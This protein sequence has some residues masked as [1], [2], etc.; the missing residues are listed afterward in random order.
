M[1]AD[2]NRTLALTEA[3]TGGVSGLDEDLL[4]I[5]CG[6]GMEKEKNAWITRTVN[7][8]RVIWA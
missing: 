6:K 4:F 8:G 5:K 7:V 3:D 2:R 1:V